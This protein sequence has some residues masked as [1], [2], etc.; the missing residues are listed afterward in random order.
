MRIRL[1]QVKGGSQERKGE[2]LE[3]SLVGNDGSLDKVAM[4]QLLFLDSERHLRVRHDLVV[5][6]SWYR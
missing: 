1:L 3:V 4:G 6:F 5:V 2:A